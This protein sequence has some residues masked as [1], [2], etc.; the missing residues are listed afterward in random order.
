MLLIEDTETFFLYKISLNVMIII[1]LKINT[2]SNKGSCQS[3]KT[4]F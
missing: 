2:R 4:L 3:G 1:T